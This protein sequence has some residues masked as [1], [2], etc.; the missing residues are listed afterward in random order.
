MEDI[1]R[2]EDQFYI[3]ATSPIADDRTRV[4][5][6]GD[7]FGVFDRYGDIQPVGMG[8]QGLYHE[9][10]R[11]LSR[12][13]L[14]LN[15]QRPLLLNSTV[16]EDNALLAVDLMNPT[17]RQNGDIVLRQ[18]TLHLFR[19]RLIWK[20]ASFE[21]LRL[22]NYGSGPFEVSLG[23]RFDADFADIF[24]VRGKKRRQRGHRLDD[25][26]RSDLVQ[27]IYRGLDGVIRR[28]KLFFSLPPQQLSSSRA[29]YEVALQPREELFF[30]LTVVC[31]VEGEPS[32]V[33][34]AYDQVFVAAGQSLKEAQAQNCAIYTSN[35]QFNDWLN[36]SLPDLHMMV[37]DTPQGPYPYAGVPWFCTPFGRD[38]IIT[39][40]EW[41]WVNPT[42]AKGVLGFL[43]A[44][45]AKEVI[46]EQDAEPGKILHETR[47]GEMAALKEIPFGRYY[48]S[49]DATPLYI[50]LAGAYFE[51]TGD[52]PFIRTIW[53]NVERALQWIDRYGD[54]DG[55]G[56]VEYARRSAEGLVHHGW[57]DSHDAVFHAD[58]TPAE[59]PIAL[60]E[61]QAY[62]YGA[63][64]RGA[65][66]AMA[67]GN[68]DQAR[69]LSN[70]AQ[71][72]QERFEETF[73]CEDLSTYALALDRRKRPC[74]VKAS[75]AGHCL[76]TGIASWHHAQ[77][78]ARTLLAE[79]F[80]SGWGIRTLSSTEARYNPM[81]YHN[82][83]VW[84]HDNALITAGLARY[85]LQQSVLKIL[86][87]LF[88]AT[89]FM[90]LHRLPE[91]FCGFV[92]R[93]GQSPTLYPVACAPHAWASASVFL[94]LQAAL[95][96]KIEATRRRV[97][98]VYPQ[99]PAF[100]K[101]VEI[102]NLKAGKASL[103]LV[104][105]RYEQDVGI[106]VARRE[107]DVEIVAVK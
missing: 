33:P 63:K 17:I 27:L 70:Q 104:L 54:A 16:K 37:T 50:L 90:D 26:V 43:A 98:F 42:I 9:G 48:G 56:F 75:N 55:D 74:R 29:T 51:R 67:L 69:D 46:P 65:E 78:V 99:L 8:A 93:P 91:L 34:P 95:G 15:D 19:S 53:P 79:E 71:A 2:V 92:R 44:T 61:V 21:R 7:T 13:E 35:E 101:E 80:F 85:G 40:L 87:G 10:T 24:E 66:L 25:E 41:L 58:G 102:R 1:I 97:L 6:Q 11:F 86:T 30:A 12:L 62:V 83:S 88:D 45:Q 31:E 36:R 52:L 106:N 96:L 100:L 107:G 60:C 32:S 64:C 18:G 72:L 68:A 49:A 20:G 57:K 23:F 38:G 28:V 22:V 73:W 76:L 105:T 14:L 82:G 94:L 59:P 39:A 77:A 5:K 103:D 47:K 3:L 81:S 84:P 89:L 4:L